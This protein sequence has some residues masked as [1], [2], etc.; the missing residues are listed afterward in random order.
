MTTE[1]ELGA[2]IATAY[3]HCRPGGVALFIPDAVKDTFQES[4]ECGGADAADGRGLRYL[5]WSYDPD[6][7]DTIATTHYA[8]VVREVDGSV[9]TLGEEHH[10]G[11]F[12]R[13]VWV[14]LLE[15]QGFAVEVVPERTDDEREP[16]LLFVARRGV[17]E[18]GRGNTSRTDH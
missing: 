9:R 4:T 18:G 5:E 8:F 16:R 13:A 3:R 14:R 2:A 10:V 15:R 17:R 6:P 12:S 7:A 11:L 1:A